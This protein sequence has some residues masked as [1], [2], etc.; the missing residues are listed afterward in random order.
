MNILI[1]CSP[2]TKSR[3]ED[4]HLQYDSQDPSGSPGT[5]QATKAV[6]LPQRD[7]T[8]SN[9]PARAN[10]FASFSRASAASTV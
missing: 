6:R 3:I 7:S 9:Q 2:K 8:R 4:P 10:R 5:C 1:H